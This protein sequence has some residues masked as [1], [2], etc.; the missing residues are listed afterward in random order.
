[1]ILI[2]TPEQLDT[3]REGGRRH[4]EIL[5]RIKEKT[6]AGVT[7]AELDAYAEQLVRE[8]GD[9]PA[10]LNYKP[11]G[12]KKPF[13]ATLCI[14]I[15]DEIVHGIPSANRVLQDGD[16]VSIDLGM[17]HNNTITDAAITVI[18][19]KA[20]KKIIDMVAAAE[21]ALYAGIEQIKPGNRIGD[22]SAAI[23]KVIGN[24]YGIVREFSGHGVGINI[25]EDPYIPNYGTA[26]TGPMLKAGMVIAIEPMIMT[27]KDAI[28]MA[29]DDWTIKT[30]DGSPAVHV[31]HTVAVTDDGYEILTTL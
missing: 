2:K 21:R 25:H 26:G 11:Y 12:A 30:K 6:V 10:F 9:I 14:S 24:K 8:G 15:N 31:E 20:D 5:Q 22:I 23:E 27:G 4:A 13:P 29:S 18:V 19:G 28:V 17:W 7:T 1:M 16:V 3:L